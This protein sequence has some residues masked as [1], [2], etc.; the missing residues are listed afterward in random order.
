MEPP[1]GLATSGTLATTAGV[2]VILEPDSLGVASA[3]GSSFNDLLHGTDWDFSGFRADGDGWNG[4]FVP[5]PLQGSDS[6]GVSSTNLVPPTA[7]SPFPNVALNPLG[8]FGG[9]GQDLASIQFT[10]THF[11]FDGLPILPA[12]GPV[13]VGFSAPQSLPQEHDSSAS[14]PHCPLSDITVQPAP[15]LPPTE[16]GVVSLPP[17]V[18]PEQDDETAISLGRSKRKP[19]P[20]LR[21]QRDNAIGEETVVPGN[22]GAKKAKNKKAKGKR[23]AENDAGASNM[24]KTK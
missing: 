20:S 19:V 2:N 5:L 15:E 16:P 23:S 1:A 13:A 4:M 3:V 11:N 7:L 8:G 6:S 22:A 12:A 18:T 24:P 17:T 10:Q 9:F 21:V 14:N